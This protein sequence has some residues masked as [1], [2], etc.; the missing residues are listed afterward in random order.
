MAF[1]NNNRTTG[2]M[3]IIP[4]T[5]LLIAGCGSGP[6]TEE[7]PVRNI[8][9]RTA[10]ASRTL[11][12]MVVTATGS[13]EADTSVT[14]STRMMGWVK[15]IHV[16]EGQTIAEGDRLLS[17][18]DTDL[19]AK[20][21]QA[22]AGIAAA[23]AVLDNAEKMAGRFE[24]LYA[25]KSV[26]KAQLDDVL[27]GREQAKAGLEM[28]KAG[29]AEVNA[30]LSYLDITAPVDGVVA[31]KMIEQ[32]NMANPGMP[33]LILEQTDR[34]KVI[35]HVGEKDVSS[36]AAGHSVT[37]E[38]SS[39]GSAVFQAELARVIPTAN[40]GSRTYDVEAY[41][42][43]PDG[44]IKS[45]MFARMTIPV[46]NRQAILVPK[47]AVINRGQLT[48][49]WIVG[50]DRIA[51]LRWVRLGRPQG[52]FVEVLSGMT[53]EETLVLSA[54]QPLSEGDRVVN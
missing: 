31:R 11:I 38:I 47:E 2:L 25:E 14:V 41:L 27:T 43:N 30:H 10:D 6:E 21:R 45:G 5:L 54:D 13:L 22:K 46:G 49:I 42:D 20:K 3:L 18:D 9:C 32:G 33:L 48:G 23:K 19:L 39:L 53:G 34:V 44:R 16:V 26:S 4:A 17:V 29:L 1:L 15:K 8:A 35:A 40:P 52:D 36:I 28:A 37:I 7:A 50:P 24:N 12:P 51:A